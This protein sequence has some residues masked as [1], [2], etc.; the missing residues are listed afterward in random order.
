MKLERNVF[1]IIDHAARTA[2]ADRPAV[3]FEGEI[4]TFRELRDRSL[5]VARGLA[6]HDVQPGDRVAV[7]LGN[8]LEWVEVLFGLAALGAICVPINVLLTGPEIAHVCADSGARCLVMDEIAEQ[9]PARLD[10]AFGLIV[11]VGTAT[12]PAGRPS[13]DYAALLAAG[14]ADAEVRGPDSG[15]TFILY[16]SS[17]TTGLPKAAEHTHD[18]VLWNA[19]G[20]LVTLGLTSD[21]RYAVIPSLSWA[22]GFHNVMLALLWIGGYSEI[23]RIGGATA[24][25]IVSMLADHDITH[26]ML[27]PSLLRMLIARPDL[28]GRLNASTLRWVVTGSEPVPRAVLDAC[29]RAMPDVA[30]CQGYGLSEFPT[31]ATVLAP[32]EVATHEGGAGR[33]LMFT[34][35]AV[36]DDTGVI[37]SSGRGELLIRSLSSMRGYFNRPE[38]TAE[39]FRDGWL[40]TGDLAELDREGFVA[41]V[42]RT[43]DMIISGGLNVYPKEIEDVLHRLPGVAEAAVV[44]VPDERFGEAPVAVV[45]TDG[46]LFSR[47]AVFTACGEQLA[48]Y[49]RPRAVLTRTDPLPRS[50]NAKLLKRELRVWAAERLSGTAPDGGLT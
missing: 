2:W 12:A 15:D 21:L 36:R 17:G 30:I 31:I 16:Y 28:T 13:V 24:A 34:D 50:A 10:A 46:T 25:N 18:G 43:K 9:P 20:Q 3:G 23:R 29:T 38:Q 4:R 33:A 39:A 41:I 47:D 26:V 14:D 48:S 19:A 6:A 27:V 44:G 7:M 1:G 35:L 22:A 45:V 49:K 11:T 32:D 37:R 40:H 5:A 8:R 42:G